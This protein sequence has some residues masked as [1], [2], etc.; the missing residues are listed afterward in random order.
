MLVFDFESGVYFDF[1]DK[2]HYGEDHWRVCAQEVADNGLV[3]ERLA[4]KDCRLIQSSSLLA[5]AEQS[6][7]SLSIGQKF[8]RLLSTSKRSDSQPGKPSFTVKVKG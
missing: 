6:L 3:N 5:A 2:S 4:I 8:S 7:G 1:F